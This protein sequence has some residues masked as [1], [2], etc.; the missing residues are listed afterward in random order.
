MLLFE[1]ITSNI[2]GLPHYSNK[3]L[4]FYHIVTAAIMQKWKAD[5]GLLKKVIWN[6]V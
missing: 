2:C 1:P 3:H 6:P 4:C 5:M